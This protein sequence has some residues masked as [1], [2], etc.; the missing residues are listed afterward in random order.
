MKSVF[1]A[2]I[3]VVASAAGGASAQMVSLIEGTRLKLHNGGGVVL[4]EGGH[5]KEQFPGVCRQG[6]IFESQ[7][8]ELFYSSRRK[9][10]ER[11]GMSYSF[12]PGSVISSCAQ[13][14]ACDNIFGYI[15]MDRVTKEQ[16]VSAG[17]TNISHIY[18]AKLVENVTI[19]VAHTYRFDGTDPAYPARFTGYL[20]EE[21]VDGV[22]PGLN[23]W[24]KVPRYF[25]ITEAG[26]GD[27]VE[28]DLTSGL[29]SLRT[30]DLAP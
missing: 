8:K 30:N 28:F 5:T 25:R 2:V 24:E 18:D 27:L 12:N 17:D 21:C 9:L 4:D 11:G 26:S 19:R 23:R 1:A 20:V 13:R 7:N 6:D 29:V 15:Y 14:M 10:L 22:A 3:F 16:R